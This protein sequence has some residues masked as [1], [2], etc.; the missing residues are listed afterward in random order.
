MN[1]GMDALLFVIAIYL[2]RAIFQS[3]KELMMFCQQM[4]CCFQPVNQP[5][6]HIALPLIF[7]PATRHIAF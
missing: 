6:S 3:M 4:P 5:V 1:S 7:F 2:P